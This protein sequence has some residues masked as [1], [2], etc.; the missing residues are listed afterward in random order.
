[1]RNAWTLIRAD[2][3]LDPDVARIACSVGLDEFG[4]IGRLALLWGWAADSDGSV[5]GVGAE[6]VDRL[7]C[8]PGFAQAMEA[9]GWLACEAAGLVFPNWDRWGSGSA[10]SRAGE[11]LRRSRTR[12]TP[13]PDKRPARTSESETPTGSSE[14]PE[15]RV[16][17]A[18]AEAEPLG[19]P[20]TESEQTTR[21][22]AGAPEAVQEA[23]R[24]QRARGP[25]VFRNC[26]RERIQD[27]QQ[28]LGWFQWH[29]RQTEC[30]KLPHL[31][32]DQESLVSV[33]AAAR[34]ACK[35]G[36]DPQKLFSKI[37]GSGDFS[38]LPGE[39]VQ[40]ARLDAGRYGLRIV[41]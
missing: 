29:F 24:Q 3:S 36:R 7:T 37:V 39:M 28:V 11:R 35:R 8:C 17:Q 5:P 20:P 38:R 10:R 25:S 1:M 14:R 12:A 2:L 19:G 4:V 6:F 21:V 26:T 31:R 30:R 23:L 32:N 18:E 13:A 33:M 15:P 16:A 40:Q 27:P 22:P 9:V 34:Y 41:G